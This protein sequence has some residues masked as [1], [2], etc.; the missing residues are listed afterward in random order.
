MHT[1]KRGDSANLV[2]SAGEECEVRIQSEETNG[3]YSVA[4]L[5]DGMFTGRIQHVNASRLRPLRG[6]YFDVRGLVST[7]SST[8]PLEG[9]E[10]IG[11]GTNRTGKAFYKVQFKDGLAEWLSEDQVFIDDEVKRAHDKQIEEDQHFK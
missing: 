9:G 8:H 2:N 7:T 4:L 11:S 3:M 6:P 5:D 1:F 10:I